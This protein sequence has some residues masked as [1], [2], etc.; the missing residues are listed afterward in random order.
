MKVVVKVTNLIRGGNMSLSH[1]KFRAFLEE[2]DA[3][4]GDL[5]LHSEIRWLS[6]GKCLVRFFGLRRKIPLFLS[7]EVKSDTTELEKELHNP[8]FLRELAF[9]ADLTA[10]LNELNLKLQGKQQSISNLYGHVNGFR[11]KLKLFKLALGNNDLTHFPSCKKLAE[12]LKDF[13]G[14]NFSVYA[15]NI[16]NILEDFKIA[17]PTLKV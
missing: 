2:I 8:E 7:D 12:E 14:A 6:A 10:H 13:E 5:L 4:Y 16:E 15:S 1:R 9:L 3:A 17:S 11:N